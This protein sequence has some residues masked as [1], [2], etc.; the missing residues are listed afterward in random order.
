MSLLDMIVLRG[1]KVT[2]VA[3]DFDIGGQEY[4]MDQIESRRSMR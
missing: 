1:S 4:H 3:C 2:T